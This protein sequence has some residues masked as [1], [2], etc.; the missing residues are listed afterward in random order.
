MFYLSHVNLLYQILYGAGDL[1][2]LTCKAACASYMYGQEFSYV[3]KTY[4]HLEKENNKDLLVFL[5][6]HKR[7]SFGFYQQ[8]Q[9][10]TTYIR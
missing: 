1:Q 2:L 9:K 5:D 3:A 8:Y 6:E 10:K 4:S 7:C